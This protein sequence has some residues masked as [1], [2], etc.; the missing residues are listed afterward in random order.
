MAG[1]HAILDSGINFSEP[2]G[3]QGIGGNAGTCERVNL[4]AT[5][6]IRFVTGTLKLWTGP[7]CTG[8]SLVVKKDV[9]NLKARG[10]GQTRSVR[11]GAA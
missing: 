1:G 5:G 10:F 7:H 3:S 6:S 2:R 8:K 4:P 9:A 11:I